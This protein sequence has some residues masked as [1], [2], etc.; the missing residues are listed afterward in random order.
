LGDSERA[1]QPG[2]GAA[3][4]SH[5]L[6]QGGTPARGWERRSLSRSMTQRRVS[7]KGGPG[8]HGWAAVGPL[9]GRVEQSR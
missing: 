6:S 3:L 4:L 1:S 2:L 8:A 5:W 9:S 7:A